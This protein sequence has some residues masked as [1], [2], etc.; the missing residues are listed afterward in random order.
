MFQWNESMRKIVDALPPEKEQL[1]HKMIQHGYDYLIKTLGG[2]PRSW[3]FAN[4]YRHETENYI[5]EKMISGTYTSKMVEVTANHAAFIFDYGWDKYCR[6]MRKPES[7]GNVKEF[8][9][10]S[11]FDDYDPLQVEIPDVVKKVYGHEDAEEILGIGAPAAI[12]AAIGIDEVEE[13]IEE[14]QP[15]LPEELNEDKGLV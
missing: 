10:D 15:Q 1:C 8:F 2:K 13:M 5:M 4:A 14:Q 7:G 9:Y 6:E 12:G 11:S 3:S